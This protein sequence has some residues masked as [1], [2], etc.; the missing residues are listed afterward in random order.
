MQPIKVI[1]RIWFGG[2][3]PER[4]KQ[5]G[6]EWADLNPGYTVHDWTEEEILDLKLINDD[7][8]EHLANPLSPNHYVDKVAMYTQRADIAGHEILY[9]VGGWY[10]N[11]DMKPIKPLDSLYD[12]Y[13]LTKAAAALED[14]VH[15]MNAACYSPEPNNPFWKMV[16]E[17]A[18]FRYFSNPE[19]IMPWSTGPQLMT[20][21]RRRNPDLITAI[22]TKVFNPLHFSEIPIGSE[23]EVDLTALPDETVACHI[24]G[25]RENGRAMGT[26]NRR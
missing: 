6:Q 1:N 5:F 12:K 25:H 18:H 19:A 14:D 7:I 3:M 9:R 17:D 22:D 2:E 24:W 16:I 4:Y 20:D 8:W 15:I 26:H 13:D 23:Y 10:F 21:V 11:T